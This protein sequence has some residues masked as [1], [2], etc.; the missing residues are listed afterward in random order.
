[1]ALKNLLIRIGLKGDKKAK[2]ALGSVNNTMTTLAATAMKVGAAFYAA[3]GII[4]GINRIVSLSGQMTSVG[5]A[6][7]NLSSAV[8]MSSNTLKSLQ[9]A[10]DGTVSSLDL[11]TQANNALLLGVVENE[12]QMAE[13]FDV[14][15]RLGAALGKDTLFGVES[16]VTG[17]GRQSK[18][19]LDN[20][21]IMIDVEEANKTYADSIGKTVK[22]LTDQ[23][24]KTAFNNE[25]MKKAKELVDGIG[26]ENLTT[27]DKLNMLKASSVN[28]AGSL[29]KTLT[30]AFNASL[31]VLSGFAKEAEG[32]V[33]FLGKIDFKAT[34]KAFLDNIQLLLDT[35]KQLFANTLDL[36]PDL[37][38]TAIN[39]ISPIA[40]KAFEKIIEVVKKIAPL[41]WDPFLITFVHIIGKINNAFVGM[42]NFMIQGVNIL[43]SKINSLGERFGVSIPEIDLVEKFNMPKLLDVLKQTDLAKELFGDEGGNNIKTIEDFNNANLELMKN[44]FDQVTVL[45]DEEEIKDKERKQRELE[46]EKE[47]NE[48]KKLTQEEFLTSVS[49]VSNQSM[50]LAEQV[51]AHGKMLRDNEMN[52]KL[53]NQQKSFDNLKKSIIAENTVNGKLTQAG[54]MALAQ[55][56]QS[57]ESKMNNIKEEARMKDVAAR[58]KLQPMKVAT[59]ISNTALAVTDAMKQVPYPFN[60]AVA[61]L[62]A[63]KGIAEVKTIQAQE[64][65]MGGLV[66]G[67]GNKDTVPAMLT[68]GEF[69]MTR[70]AV[71]QIGVDNLKQM[72]EGGGSGIT[73]NVSAPLVDETILD[74]I[75][76]KLEEARRLQL[77]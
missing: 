54:Q 56:E 62:V 33:D 13:M 10:T 73:L 53:K 66:G 71:N 21:G 12:G 23:E 32:A 63:A 43:S 18:L 61:A 47:H 20:L 64:F 38:R 11:M 31:D 37:W 77:A 44:F 5:N 24:R 59:A 58:K 50:A 3:K 28:L 29:G 65:A 68:P 74:V 22:E 57:H 76:P 75:I 16:L 49:A 48:Q 41:L 52:D 2:K 72:N 34:G 46:E 55:L 45:K 8:G 27:A 60:F 35:F 26:E 42:I 14:A 51:F 15:Q 9:T 19:M 6:F 17:M 69:V 40:L 39:K 70:Q 25:T 67:V 1:M 4:T 30:P 36:I 7:N